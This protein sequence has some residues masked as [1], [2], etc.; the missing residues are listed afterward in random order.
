L[1][2]RYKENKS[3]CINWVLS[4]KKSPKLIGDF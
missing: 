2:K 1:R 4:K 3:L